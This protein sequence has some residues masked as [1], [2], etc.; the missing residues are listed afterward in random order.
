MNQYFKLPNV[1]AFNPA[2]AHLNQVA[3]SLASL[4]EMV[5]MDTIREC[6]DNEWLDGLREEAKKSAASLG[7]LAEQAAIRHHESKN[8]TTTGETT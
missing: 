5:D 8:S 1:P 3:G 4:I 2:S 7:W 6:H